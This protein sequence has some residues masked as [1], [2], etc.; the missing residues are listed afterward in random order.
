MVLSREALLWVSRRL[1][2]ASNYKGR[3]YKTWKCIDRSTHLFFSM[4]F[5]N[6]GRYILVITVIG[7]SKTA[8]RVLENAFNESWLNVTLKMESIIK[9]GLH[10][11]EALNIKE[12]KEGKIIRGEKSFKELLQKPRWS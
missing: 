11:R 3:V 9:K 8:I 6:F 4:K 10:S 7:E 2:E 1:R 12:A 5:N